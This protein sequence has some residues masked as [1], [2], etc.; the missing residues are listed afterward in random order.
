MA[1]LGTTHV[2]AANPSSKDSFT[3]LNRFG[4]MVHEYFVEHVR[5]VERQANK[6][7]AALRTRADAETYVRDVRRKIQRSFGP[8]PEKTP[9]RPRITGI[10]EHDTY[11]IEKLIF[12]SRPE[13]LVTAN[14]YIPKGRE[15]P[16]PGVVGT[17]GHSANGKAAEAYQGF[18]QGLARQGYVVLL[19]D[20]IGQGER[21][22]Y[23]NENL[24]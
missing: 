24:R 5:A 16:L 22:Q 4:R 9:L 18:A 1:W 19:Y 6:H 2:Q 15:F 11:K 23:P 17:C 7:R 21:L 10:I 3:P 8:W 20:P 13:F 12:E 14:L